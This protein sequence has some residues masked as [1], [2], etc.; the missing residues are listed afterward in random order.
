[1]PWSRPGHALTLSTAAG[2]HPEVG[3]ARGHSEPIPTPLSK[4]S[5]RAEKGGVAMKIV[6]TLEDIWKRF[7]M[8]SGSAVEIHVQYPSYRSKIDVTYG[9]ESMLRPV[10]GPSGPASD[11]PVE[12]L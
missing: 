3:D 5:A 7:G 2:H 8:D 10:D 12:E 1:M 11:A 6:L 4:A 9:G